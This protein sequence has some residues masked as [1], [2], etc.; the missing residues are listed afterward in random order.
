MPIMDGI[1]CARHIRSSDDES[2]ALMPLI[3]VTANMREYGDSLE[4]CNIN[5]LVSKPVDVNI[6][7][8]AIKKCLSEKT[9]NE[10]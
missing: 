1:E 8:D 6:L 3:A 7:K 2:L 5:G 4:G 9:P 10:D